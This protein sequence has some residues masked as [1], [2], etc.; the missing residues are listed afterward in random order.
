MRILYVALTRAKE[1]LFITGLSK[2]YEK[3]SEKLEQQVNRYDKEF[4]KINPILVKKY[5]RYLDWILLVYKYE[6]SKMKDLAELNIYNKKELLNTFK[7]SDKEEID[8]VELLEKEE[9]EQ[10]KIIN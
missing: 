1:K 2:D 8:I 7:D 4:D 10:N 3:E 9:V 5:K 6:E